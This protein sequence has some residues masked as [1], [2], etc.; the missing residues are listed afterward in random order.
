MSEQLK[1]SCVLNLLEASV[2]IYENLHL[3][4][5]SP[6]WLNLSLFALSII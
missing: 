1:A 2:Y 6:R 4:L 3:V 5:L